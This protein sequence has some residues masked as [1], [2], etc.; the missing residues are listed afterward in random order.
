M[1]S[2][3]APT[4]P[5]GRTSAMRALLLA[6][7]GGLAVGSVVLE[8]TPDHL[9]GIH[10]SLVIAVVVAGLIVGRAARREL[11]LQGF[12]EVAGFAFA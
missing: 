10:A 11:A 8:R 3:A 7:V 2:S 9:T 4:C 6:M 12:W 1:A 5:R